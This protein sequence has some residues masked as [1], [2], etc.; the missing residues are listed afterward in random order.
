[1][2]AS[3]GEGPAKVIWFIIGWGIVLFILEAV[4]FG[5]RKR[6]KARR[7]YGP[8]PQYRADVQ[9]QVQHDVTHTMQNIDQRHAEA[10]RR[11]WDIF[12]QHQRP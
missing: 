3:W 12:H 4:V 8:V 7:D 5:I 2:L 9:Q 6:L 10:K 1:M 11:M